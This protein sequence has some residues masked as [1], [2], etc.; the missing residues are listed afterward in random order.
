[1]RW[2]PARGLA[3]SFAALVRK[4]ETVRFP[5]VPPE[6]PEGFRG[7]PE[8]DEPECVGCG[9]CAAVC[10]SGAIRVV[11]PKP[12][13]A[14]KKKRQVRR[15]EFRYDTCNFCGLCEDRCITRRGI[16]QG[17]KY[18]LA[19]L[20]RKL[21]MEHVEKELALCEGCGRVLSAR[22]HMHWIARALG[23]A[24]YANPTLSLAVDPCETDRKSVV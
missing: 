20:D 21:A 9:A 1:M 17:R 22:E 6:L 7:K 15:I 14:A 13:V 5:R 2:I 11:D 4:P 24:A 23:T 12:S 3:K 16:R 19:L 18:D 10:P 8:F